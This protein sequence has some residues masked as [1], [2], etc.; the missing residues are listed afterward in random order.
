MTAEGGRGDL[1]EKPKTTPLGLGFCER[2]T[3]GLGFG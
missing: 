3:E 1:D 2:N